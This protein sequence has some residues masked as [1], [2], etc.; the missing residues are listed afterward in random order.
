MTTIEFA[1]QLMSFDGQDLLAANAIEDINDTPSHH[2]PDDTW[3]RMLMRGVQEGLAR[4]GYRLERTG[5]ADKA[6]AQALV[7]VVGPRWRYQTWLDIYGA[8]Q[9]CS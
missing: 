8:L 1:R 4:L 3:R 7:A 2:L 5:V 6:T 9:A